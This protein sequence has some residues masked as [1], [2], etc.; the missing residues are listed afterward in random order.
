MFD[1]TGIYELRGL[2]KI[3][4]QDFVRILCI[5][6]M[7]MTDESKIIPISQDGCIVVISSCRWRIGCG[8]RLSRDKLM[9]SCG[10]AIQQVTGGS[11]HAA[12]RGSNLWSH[13]MGVG[14]PSGQVKVGHTEY[15]SAV[16]PVMYT[17]MPWKRG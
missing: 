6:G 15:F 14:C 12:S 16:M 3:S 1:S 9:T 10:M 13:V 7:V 11:G 8:T 5:E 2:K 17:S 4:L